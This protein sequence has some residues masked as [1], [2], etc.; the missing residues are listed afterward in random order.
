MEKKNFTVFYYNQFN[1]LILN[2]LIS[3]WTV[4]YKTKTKKLLDEFKMCVT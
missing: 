4:H 3:I 1:K 2:Y